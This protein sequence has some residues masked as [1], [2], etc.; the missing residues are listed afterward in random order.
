MIVVSISILI[1]TSSHLFWDAFTHDN[2]FFVE[3]V[4]I[5]TKELTL[6]R[7]EAP[8]YKIFKL[9]CSIIGEIIILVVIL[10][11][12]KQPLGHNRSNPGYWLVVT[13]LSFT[14]FVIRVYTG[15]RFDQEFN[16]VMTFI[17]GCLIALVLASLIFRENYNS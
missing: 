17:S 12:K 15:L 14:I 16:I 6:G 4:S 13:G 2:G 8:V 5:L 3:R 10:Q 11:N 9:L 1:G 7:I